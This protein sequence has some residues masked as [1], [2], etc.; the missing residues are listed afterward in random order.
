MVHSTFKLLVLRKASTAQHLHQHHHPPFN[1]NKRSHTPEDGTPTAGPTQVKRATSED[2]TVTVKIEKPSFTG[3]F[4]SV[5]YLNQSASKMVIVGLSQSNNFKPYVQIKSAKGIGCI[6]S[7]DEW[8]RMIQELKYINNY[9]FADDKVPFDDL[10]L[11]GHVLAVSTS[12]Y[13]NSTLVGITAHHDTF[14]RVLLAEVSVKRLLHLDTVVK[15]VLE[16]LERIAENVFEWYRNFLELV[17]LNYKKL[18]VDRKNV[19]K[20]VT[21]YVASYKP[22]KNDDFFFNVPRAFYELSLT[23]IIFHVNQKLI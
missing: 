16:D 18:H 3:I 15:E 9:I 8:M 20:Q 5:F 11:G 2:T 6:L 12:P 21:D 14:S 17:T 13:E 1:M 22:D 19:K 23:Q 10:D 7:Y 4:Q